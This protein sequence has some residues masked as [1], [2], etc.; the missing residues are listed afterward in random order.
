M[1]LSVWMCVC[2]LSY[3]RLVSHRGVYSTFDPDQDKAGTEDKLMN[4]WMNEWSN[5]SLKTE[6]EI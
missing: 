3:N 4:E 5:L 1:W 6:S 2:M